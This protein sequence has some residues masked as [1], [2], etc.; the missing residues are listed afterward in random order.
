MSNRLSRKAD[1]QTATV[2]PCAG[3][4]L[5]LGMP[6]LR[7]IT[8]IGV[9]VLLGAVVLGLDFAAGVSGRY[10]QALRKDLQ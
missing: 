3:T 9:V 2:Y 8:W 4:A 6:Q 7:A 1:I 10:P 5:G